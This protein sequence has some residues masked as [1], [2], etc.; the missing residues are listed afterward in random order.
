MAVYGKIGQNNQVSF[1]F[2]DL[3]TWHSCLH[4]TFEAF[5]RM[6]KS[7]QIILLTL[8][9]KHENRDNSKGVRSEAIY[10]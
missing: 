5:H 7:V 10:A 8:S 9:N 4:L 6:R 3:F 1:F 2:A